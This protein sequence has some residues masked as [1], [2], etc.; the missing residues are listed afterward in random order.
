MAGEVISDP[1]MKEATDAVTR[2]NQE[3]LTFHT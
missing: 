3:L 2:A 1:I